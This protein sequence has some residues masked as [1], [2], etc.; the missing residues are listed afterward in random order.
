MK[1]SSLVLF[2]SVVLAA[3]CA[4]GSYGSASITQVSDPAAR[5]DFVSWISIPEGD[6]VSAVI[7][8][9]AVDGDS[10]TA[11]LTSQNPGILNV[12]AVPGDPAT[13]VFLGVRRGTTTVEVMANGRP[14]TTVHAVVLPPSEGSATYTPFDGG[15]TPGSDAGVDA[16]HGDGG[17]VPREAAPDAVQDA[18]HDRDAVPDAVHDAKHDRDAVP[19]AVHDAKHDRDA[20]PDAATDAEHDVGAASDAAPDASNG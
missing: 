4:D 6:A 13:F 18:R 9:T 3:A 2:A 8:L 16:A 14:A 1:R 10:M 12:L 15:T 7:Q 11:S 5:I 17:H 19:D 20:A